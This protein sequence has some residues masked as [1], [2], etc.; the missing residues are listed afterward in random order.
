MFWNLLGFQKILDTLFDDG[1]C[2]L[3]LPEGHG[4]GDIQPAD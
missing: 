2:S 1:W 3:G 4:C